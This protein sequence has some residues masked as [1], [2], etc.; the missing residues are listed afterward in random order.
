[1]QQRA[2]ETIINSRAQATFKEETAQSSV[3][4]PFCHEVS[5]S[6]WPDLVIRQNLDIQIVKQ[7]V[8]IFTYSDKFK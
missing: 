7:N 6:G 5:F 3:L 4:D 8:S 1:M 2:I